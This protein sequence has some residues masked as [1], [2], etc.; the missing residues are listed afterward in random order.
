ELTFY[1]IRHA[2]SIKNTF[3][4]VIGGRSGESP[5]TDNGRHQARVLG[6]NLQNIK[7]DHIFTS[8]FSRAVETT[9]LVFPKNGWSAHD[10]L[11]ELDQGQWQG[12][13]RAE[14]YTDEQLAYMNSKGY[15]FTPPEGESQR[16]VEKR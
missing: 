14:V 11:M 16:Q 5:L 1:F 4:D 7:F 10:E 8:P 2:E 13:K 6:L 9:K 15:F 12:Q 3:P